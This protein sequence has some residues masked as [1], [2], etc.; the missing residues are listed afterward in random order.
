MIPIAA[1]AIMQQIAELLAAG[2]ESLRETAQK[3]VDKYNELK[4]LVK[5]L[6]VRRSP[7]IYILEAPR[8]QTKDS[9]HHAS[10]NTTTS[11]PASTRLLIV[12]T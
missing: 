1:D 4:A 12:L 10:K 8:N 5:D 7:S 9:L 11:S 3:K 6:R 2:V